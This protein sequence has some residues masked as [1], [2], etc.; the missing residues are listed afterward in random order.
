MLMISHDIAFLN[1]L[2][3]RVIVMKNGIIVD[4]FNVENL[5]SNQRHEYTKQLLSI[6]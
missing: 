3:E 4:D 6:Y 2:V 1:H 5:F